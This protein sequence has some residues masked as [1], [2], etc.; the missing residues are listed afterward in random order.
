MELEPKV[1]HL[2]HPDSYGYRP[3]KSALDA[4]GTCRQRCWRYDWVVDLDIK[5]FFDNIDHHI[6]EKL[7]RRHFN[8]ARLFHLYWKIVKAG[9]VSWDNNKRTFVASDLGVPQG[10]IISPIL[11]NLVLHEQD[12]LIEKKIREYEDSSKGVKPYLTNPKYHKLTM[13]IKRLKSKIDSIRSHS[14][15][16]WPQIKSLK[17]EYHK[18]IKERRLLKSMIPNPLI[19]TIK[20]VR[21]ADDWL[22][23]LWGCKEKARA[24]KEEIGIFLKNML[25]ELSL[26]KTL[27]T[28]ARSDR[29]KF[30][31]TYIKRLTSNTGNAIYIA[32]GKDN[33]PN[34]RIPSGN[35]WMSAPILDIAKRLESKGFMK[36]NNNRWNAKVIRSFSL[37]P[38]KDIILRY[39][40][41]LNGFIN[42]YS[43]SDN[44][45]RFNKIHWILKESL[46]KT[47][48][49]KLKIGKR[50]FIKRFGEDI[51]V[52]YKS[53][54]KKDKEGRGGVPSL[55]PLPPSFINFK[56]PDLTRRPMLFLGA[57]R[58]TDP[59]SNII[60]KVSTVNAF[61]KPCA[62][63]GSN[64]DIEMHHLKH[65]KTINIKLN[66][67][68]KKMA[69]IN[70]KQI[71]LCRTCH[72]AVH[73]GK[74]KGFA[75]NHL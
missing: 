39:K 54:D 14:V 35:L 48:C 60:W 64:S 47:I 7:L 74:Y 31:G 19:T 8:E 9:Y 61:G 2:F 28:N 27:I 70:R 65:I 71:P 10:S 4:V 40:S 50:A 30:L 59:A 72:I 44:R 11:S 20:Y 37:L 58:F 26:E 17:F 34:R 21:Y 33:G 73:Q 29:A 24:L 12:K 55:R 45:L 43:F 6:L 51:I 62:N 52:K 32:N 36:S 57:A 53:N 42:Y 23:G 56:V 18:F 25:L 13:R 22:I 67:F 66:H 1:E 41:I 5:G 63:C 46:R 68:D 15:E 16:T 69:S 3:G 49:Y 75:L 38:I